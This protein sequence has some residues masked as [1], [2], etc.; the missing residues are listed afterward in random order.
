MQRVK[1]N[2]PVAGSVQRHPSLSDRARLWRWRSNTRCLDEPGGLGFQLNAL[3]YQVRSVSKIIIFHIRVTINTMFAGFY[4][5]V[6][7]GLRCL[8]VHISYPERQ[9]IFRHPR[10]RQIILNGAG[11][12]RLLHQIVR[13]KFLLFQCLIKIGNEIINIFQSYSS[14]QSSIPR[15][16]LILSKAS[17][18]VEHW[19]GDERLQHL[20]GFRHE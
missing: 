20:Q 18:W 4:K 5:R 15:D 2:K 1:G 8:E 19:I 3:L 7:N 6:D 9:D 17:A 14:R 12:F 11:I 13:H 10:L 16:S